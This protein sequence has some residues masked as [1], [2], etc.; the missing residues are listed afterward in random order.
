MLVR[1]AQPDLVQPAGINSV[2]I[3]VSSVS[4]S[5]LH[6]L[7]ALDGRRCREAEVTGVAAE[8]LACAYAT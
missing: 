4:V 7:R 8:T 6:V 5:W 3:E 1:S 2:H